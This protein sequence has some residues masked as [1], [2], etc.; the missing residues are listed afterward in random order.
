M[1]PMALYLQALSC[2]SSSCGW[3]FEYGEYHYKVYCLPY[4]QG[5]YKDRNA[6]GFYAVG[7]WE[8]VK[9][10]AAI[11]QNQQLDINRIVV[12][13]AVR[14]PYVKTGQERVCQPAQSSPSHVPYTLAQTEWC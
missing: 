13:N 8:I 2:T 3:S 10:I 12:M 1:W 4:R 5:N 6:H 9:I 14:Y 7:C 11:M